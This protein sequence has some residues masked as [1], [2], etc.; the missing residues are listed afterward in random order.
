MGSVSKFGLVASIGWLLTGPTGWAVGFRIPNQDAEAVA[1]GNAFTATAD[2]PS[3]VYY[4][5]AGITQL[6]GENVEFSIYNISV[7]SQYRSPAGHQSH[8]QFG[9]EPVPQLYFTYKPEK[10]PFSFGLGLYEP[11]GSGLKWPD[12]SGFRTITTNSHLEYICLNPVVACQITR[13]LSIGGGPQLEY[14]KALLES[15]LLPTPGNQF[16][17][18]G[19]GFSY[20]FNLGVLWKPDPHWSL[21]AAYQAPTSID[22]NGN[23]ELHP[24]A[25]E[26][27]AHGRL[28]FPQ[29]VRAGVSYRPND[30][31]NLE[32]DIDW[33]DWDDLDTSTIHSQS[34]GNLAVPFAWQSSFFYELGVTRY[35]PSGFSVSGGYLYNENSVRSEKF[36]PAVPDTN[37]H[38]FS[39]G[40]AYQHGHWRYALTYQLTVGPWR[41]V[42]GSAPSLAG[43]SADGAYRFFNHG[44]ALSIGYHF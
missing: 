31:W 12:D 13:D 24:I 6:S 8:T 30:D 29:F 2:N 36:S 42:S 28:T 38:V 44:V 39:T 43:Q 26:Q 27:D 32:A 33:T 16:K 41:D 21:G 35:F 20:G 3:A 19:E 22:L 17:F 15:G 40:G 23:V 7:N 25:P 10:G 34:L 11:Y 14:G 37:F 1:R 18:D 5:P 4:N 9:I